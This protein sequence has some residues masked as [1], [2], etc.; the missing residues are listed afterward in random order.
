MKEH[1][2]SSVEAGTIKKFRTLAGG[3]RKVGEFLSELA[4]LLWKH[5]AIVENTKVQN[6]VIAAQPTHPDLEAIVRDQ[7]EMIDDLAKRM[8][9][10]EIELR[11]FRAVVENAV[12]ISEESDGKQT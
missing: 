9:R 1:L 10:Q 7:D 5:R 3:P 2:S 6:L 12:R 11:Y 8:D 4:N